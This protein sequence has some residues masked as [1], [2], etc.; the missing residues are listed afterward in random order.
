MIQPLSSIPR[1]AFAL[2]G[3]MSVAEAERRAESEEYISQMEALT[4]AYIVTPIV[5]ASG[6]T[7]GYVFF[8]VSGLIVAAITSAG[9]MLHIL[10]RYHAGAAPSPAEA[11]RLFEQAASTSDNAVL[12]DEQA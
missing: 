7:C 8:Y 11:V 12:S 2:I 9:D 10:A 5:T 4:F 6:Y 3:V 1:E